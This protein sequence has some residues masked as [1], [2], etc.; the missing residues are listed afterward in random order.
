MMNDKKMNLKEENAEVNN[1]EESFVIPNEAA[2]SH[3]FADGCII[4]EDEAD[5]YFEEK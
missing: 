4:M 5:K 2:C 1:K 3:E